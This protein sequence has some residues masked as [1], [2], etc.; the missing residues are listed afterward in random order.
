MLMAPLAVPPSVGNNLSAF[1]FARAS[2]RLTPGISI[3]TWHKALT[4]GIV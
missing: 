4:S 2:C 3:K 1:P